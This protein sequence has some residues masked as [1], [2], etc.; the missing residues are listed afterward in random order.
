MVFT[1]LF[2]AILSNNFISNLRNRSPE[3]FVEEIR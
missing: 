1:R 2:K 3:V